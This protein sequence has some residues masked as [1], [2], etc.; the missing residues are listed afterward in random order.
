MSLLLTIPLTWGQTSVFFCDEK[1][2]ED[3]PIQAAGRVKPLLVHA[4]E[5][6][7]FLTGTKKHPEHSALLAYC[8]LSLKGLGLTTPSVELRA[9]LE[10]EKVRSLLSTQEKNISFEKFVSEENLLRTELSKLKE[11]DAYKKEIT[12]PIQ[13][14]HLYQEIKDASNWMLPEKT[15]DSFE[16]LPLH[17]FLKEEKIEAIL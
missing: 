8:Y 1:L 15:Q 13:R 9:P 2:L 4:Q 6:M 17:S 7:K 10:H 14:I 5:V 3:F 12:R 16:W 11:N